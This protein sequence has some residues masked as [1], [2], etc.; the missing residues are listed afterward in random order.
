M[1]ADPGGAQC[2]TTG[3]TSC[4]VTGLTDGTGYTFTV[5]A[6]NQV[7]ESDPSAASETVTPQTTPSA[8]SIPET[9]PG[10][11]QV[12]LTWTAPTSTGG[13]AITGYTVTAD[14]GGA[15][16][17]TT[18]ATSC[19]IT[20]LTNNTSYTFTVTATNAEGDGPASNPTAPI[21][22][23]FVPGSPTGIAITPSNSAVTVTWTA[24][25]NSGGTEITGYTATASPGGAQCTTTDATS[26]TITGLTNGTGYTVTVTATN[27][28][29]TSEP[30]QASASATPIT[31][32]S[33]PTSVSATADD[34]RATVS[35]TT[36]SDTGGS[37]D[38]L[39]HRHRLTW[40]HHLRHQF[41]R[42][43]HLR[44]RKTA[45]ATDSPSPP[46]TPPLAQA[47][48]RLSQT[49]SHRVRPAHQRACA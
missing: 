19:A 40:R 8:P 37:G 35:W 33:S 17:T 44:P 36:P 24:P 5:T 46:P 16:C 31:V 27:I 21:A 6:T 1:T 23:G 41:H 45:P 32:P 30:S 18:G 28:V 29:G 14:P 47:P 12:E 15:Q 7:G 13:S 39:L 49:L 25:A 10:D 38:Y 4:T 48:P 42:L 11:G 9:T 3:E 2:T 20:G 34:G 22:P 26:C 43:H